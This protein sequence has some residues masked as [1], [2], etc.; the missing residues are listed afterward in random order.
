MLQCVRPYVPSCEAL[1]GLVAEGDDTIE[2]ASGAENIVDRAR[3]LFADVHV[4]LLAQNTHRV[5]MDAVLRRD[6]G[7]YHGYPSIRSVT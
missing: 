4:E 3:R 1:A 6:A 5:G 7:A 2:V